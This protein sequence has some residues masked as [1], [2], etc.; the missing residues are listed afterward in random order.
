MNFI[1]NIIPPKATH[2]S[3][4]T[5][6]K[7]RK[8][9]QMFIGKKSSSASTA[10]KKLL[11]NA[12]WPFR[13]EAPFEGP[14]CLEVLWVY[15]WRKSETKKNR[16]LNIMCCDTRPDCDNLN[17]T[18]A[19]QLSD[20]GFWKDDGQ[21]SDLIFRKRWGDRPRIEVSITPAQ[22]LPQGTLGL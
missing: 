14:L 6:M 7:N 19:D 18:F 2:Q 5:I 8:T 10:A 15:P 11:R 17:K 1:L 9:G 12:L 16:A 3:G 20:L 21:V 13:P 4:S 22:A